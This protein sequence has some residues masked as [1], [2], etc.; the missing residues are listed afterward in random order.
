MQISGV[1]TTRYEA[2]AHSLLYKLMNEKA[3]GLDIFKLKLK[4][5]NVSNETAR[6]MGREGQWPRS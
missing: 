6:Q 4:F 1:Q 2:N 3:R 5:G